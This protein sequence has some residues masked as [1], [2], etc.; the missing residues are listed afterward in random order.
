[1]GNFPT[2]GQ[3][4]NVCMEFVKLMRLHPSPENSEHRND[5][6]MLNKNQRGIKIRGNKIVNEKRKR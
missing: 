1:M 4:I 2:V 5:C 6:G 3:S